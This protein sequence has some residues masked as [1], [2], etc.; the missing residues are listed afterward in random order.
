MFNNMPTSE[1][2]RIATGQ[3]FHYRRHRR[4]SMAYHLHPA[5]QFVDAVPGFSVKGRLFPSPASPRL[6]TNLLVVAESLRSVPLIVAVPAPVF[7]CAST[8]MICRG[9]RRP[10]CSGSGAISR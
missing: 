5:T 6:Y 9:C 4:R 1:R 10:E 8:G 7:W 2:L 3:H